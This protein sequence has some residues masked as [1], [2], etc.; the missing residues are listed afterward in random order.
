VYGVPFAGKTYLQH[1]LWDA[2]IS[3][4]DTDTMIEDECGRMIARFIKQLKHAFWDHGGVVSNMVMEYTLTHPDGTNP[5]LPWLEEY[6]DFKDRAELSH[7][8]KDRVYAKLGLAETYEDPF[9]VHGKGPA[10]VVFTNLTSLPWYDVGFFRPPE[11]AVSHNK[12][13]TRTYLGSEGEF[14]RTAIGPSN[15]TLAGWYAKAFT[16]CERVDKVI[17]LDDD[18]YI[19]TA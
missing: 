19:Y 13:R 18:E 17:V 9:L 3:T 6:A 7:L 1:K 12:M 4:L 16:I 5:L 8:A 11:Q 2:G 10:Q 15:A 14:E